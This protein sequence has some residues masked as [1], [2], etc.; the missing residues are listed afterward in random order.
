MLK[1]L[2][3]EELGET[4]SGENLASN[5]TEENLLCS[6]AV[7]NNISRTAMERLV[8]MLR[9]NNF[10]TNNLKHVNYKNMRISWN[11]QRPL[12]KTTI[13]V[14]VVPVITTGSRSKNKKTR[15][16]EFMAF[17]PLLHQL[18][19][20]IEVIQILYQSSYPKPCLNRSSSHTF[21]YIIYSSSFWNLLLVKVL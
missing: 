5:T 17:N 2:E 19:D 1:N 8:E 21:Q 14:P 3:L 16:E 10:Q 13:T 7:Q 4:N 9:E 6:F 12:H 15:I 11:K 18:S 20:K